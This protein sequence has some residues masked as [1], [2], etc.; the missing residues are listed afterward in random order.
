MKQLIILGALVILLVNAANA[1]NPPPPDPKLPVIL[2]PS[3]EAASITK[4]GDLNVGLYNGA[5][6][7]AIP[8]YEIKLKD[9]T[10]P[11]SLNYGSNGTKVDEI[12]SRVGMNWSLNAG[13]VITRSVNGRPDDLST[14]RPPP[15]YLGSDFTSL[16]YYYDVTVETN[17]YDSEPDEFH[18][19]G[20]GLSGKFI[21][22]NTNQPILIPHGNLKIQMNGLNPF[23]EIIVTNTEGVKFR[24]GGIATEVTTN[25]T[26]GG[27]LQAL[28]S[29]STGF[30]LNR[31]ELLNGDF[32]QFNYSV[33]STKQYTGVTQSVRYGRQPT[34]EPTC[35]NIPCDIGFLNYNESASSTTYN[36]LLLNSIS[37]SNGTTVNFTYENRP[38][39]GG[40]KRLTTITVSGSSVIKNYKLAYEDQTIWSNYTSNNF[41]SY[42][43]RF[44][45]KELKTILPQTNGVVDTL[46]HKL[47]YIDI[48][49]L[50]QRLSTAQDNFGYFNGKGGSYMLP[51]GY[52]DFG[53]YGVADRSPDGNYAMKG[54]LQKI[55]FPTGGYQLFEYEPNNTF[56]SG[57][58][59]ANNTVVSVYGQGS[60]A[61]GI[62][63]FT[64]STIA[65]VRDQTA[66]LNISATISPSCVSCQA[67][68]IGVDN[69]VEVKIFNLT[70]ST[71][72]AILYRRFQDFIS[73]TRT[74][75]LLANNTYKIELKVRGD[76]CYG[77]VEFTY[78]PLTAP[79]YVPVYK[80]E[81]GI[82]VKNI[83]NYDHITN[84]F[85]NRYFRYSFLNNLS[86]SSGI[87]ITAFKYIAKGYNKIE[88]GIQNTYA[89]CPS[90]ILSSNSN[91]QQ[92]LYDNS[93]FVYEAVL[94][95]DDPNFANG[96]AEHIYE[97]TSFTWG[98]QILGNEGLGYFPANT[99]T[100]YNGF[101]KATRYYNQSLTL[102][103]EANNYYHV[104]QAV[105]KE[106]RSVIV[107]K[108][109]DMLPPT[110]PISSDEID[111]Y[112]VTY[113]LYQSNWIQ[114]DSTV[115]KEYDENGR[116]QYSKAAY[117]YGT[118]AN[119]AA[120]R[121]ENINS[122]GELLKVENK[123]VTDFPAA[124]PYSRMISFNMISPVVESK[125]YNNSN[126][127]YTTNNIYYDFSINQNAGTPVIIKPKTVQVQKG[128][129]GP[130]E[131][132]LQFYSYDDKGNPVELAK[133]KDTKVFYI[134]DY[135]KEY[136]VAEI[137]NSDAGSAAY[138][139]FE[140]DGKGNWS[141]TGTPVSDATAPTGKKVYDP[142]LGP[143]T[144]SISTAGNYIVT[145]WSKNGAKSVNGSSS[146]AARNI[147]GWV[148][149]EHKL[150][151]AA[152]ATVTVSGSGVID[153]LRLYPEKA[154]MTTMTYEPLIGITSQCDPNN[155][156][157][158]YEYDPFN[159]LIVI[160]DHDKNI[161]KKICYNYAGHP[162]TCTTTP[163]PPPPPVCDASTCVGDDRKCVNGNCE[164]GTLGVVSAV[165]KKVLVD[166]V[167]VFK[168]VCTYRYCFSNGTQSTYSVVDNSDN[169]CPVTCF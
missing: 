70:T 168:W 41:G 156:M 151:L 23:N 167:L 17:N 31:I 1:Q 27:K 35:G 155:R 146:A 13:G 34:T 139:S 68:E 106:L 116:V 79:V 77:N 87:P 147:S 86:G 9:F 123:F 5:A 111:P 88:C 101:E 49:G 143:I 152:G 54:M 74:L 71:T 109:Y 25:H 107:R 154:L 131:S 120:A 50:P 52:G 93:P 134:W 102:K 80:Q 97:A 133:E 169:P 10:L 128:A 14:R 127:T 121:V 150:T 55:T 72:T 15:A 39:N 138:T 33:I 28:T 157:S 159:R 94:E 12:P 158:Y 57:L 78:D 95:S 8:I 69:F 83:K 99:N 125:T 124:L 149:Y 90:E 64:N 38:D 142:A 60:G 84:K 4:G 51:A 105:N 140:S 104:D 56:T 130:L 96:V 119:I 92:Y 145:Y 136:P 115:T 161:I 44:F 37:A 7:A 29:I 67:P 2:P 22:D 122:K 132:R 63:V 100:Y 11:I 162:E 98:Q 46:R 40:D 110:V 103:K 21:L 117:Y 114:Q 42:N 16:N 19:S 135:N 148:Y 160:R 144:K 65:P 61:T 85:N 30:F 129:T 43:K 89:V 53:S 91:A 113:Y 153:E 24:F 59:P 137:K 126:L 18:I 6:Q 163:P 47:E 66:K 36:S 73:E 76:Y 108:K 45:L 26:V 62:N 165:W 112:D 3:P 118:P 82:R 32:I 164:I 48:S 166:G 75:N 58:S 81:S 20:P 141:F